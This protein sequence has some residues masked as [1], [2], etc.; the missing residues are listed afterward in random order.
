MLK[1]IS[2]LLVLLSVGCG[3]SHNVIVENSEHVGYI[4]VAET[5]REV[6]ND[7]FNKYDY[8][9]VL[10]LAVIKAECRRK[11]ATGEEELEIPQI[12]GG[13]N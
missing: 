13:L 5:W 9:D 2:V 3:T 11:F 10:E 7:R 12:P 6:C 4:S 8:P 1:I